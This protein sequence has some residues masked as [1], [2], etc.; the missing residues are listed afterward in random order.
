[1]SD[2]YDPSGAL[3]HLVS[4][5]QSRG[6]SAEH[7]QGMHPAVR[8]H[9]AKMAGLNAPTEEGWATVIDHMRKGS[10]RAPSRDLSQM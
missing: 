7:L 6:V 3:I 1:M 4:H 5:F 10:P 2:T 8:T 9:Y